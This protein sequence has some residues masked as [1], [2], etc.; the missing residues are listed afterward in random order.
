MLATT[1][2]YTHTSFV[3]DGTQEVCVCK[4]AEEDICMPQHAYIHIPRSSLMTRRKYVYVSVRRRINAGHNTRIYIY[5][6][7]R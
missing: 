7:R 6:V 3:V 4:C 2:V 1:R 5:L